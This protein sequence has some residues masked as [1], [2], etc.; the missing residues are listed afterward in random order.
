M[1]IKKLFRTILTV[2][3]HFLNGVNIDEISKVDY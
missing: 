3:S 1:I 2:N